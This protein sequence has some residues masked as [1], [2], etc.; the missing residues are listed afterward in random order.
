VVGALYL[1]EGHEARLVATSRAPAESLPLRFD[2]GGPS[3]VARAARE[4]RPI[5]STAERELAGGHDAAG[6]PVCVLPIERAGKE[7]PSAV[8]VAG[9]NPMRGLDEAYRDFFG[10]VA[11]QI[12]AAIANAEER[13]RAEALAEVAEAKTTF[14]SNV[15]H[16]FRTP[17]TLLLGPLQDTLANR[18]EPLPPRVCEAIELAQRNAQRL[19]KLV[20][21]LLDFSRIEAGRM[22]ASYVA[23]DLAAATRDLASMFRSAIDRAGLA[24]D[25]AGIEDLPQPVFVDRA[26]WEKIVS[27]LLSNAFKFTFEGRIRVVVRAAGE[28]AEVAIEDTGVGIAEHDLPKLFQR[29]HRIEGAPS[30][31]YEGSGIGLSFVHSLVGLHGA[32]IAVTSRLGEGSRFTITIPF[33]S[34]H[35]PP[36]RVD[37]S[38]P[39]PHRHRAPAHGWLRGRPATAGHVRREVPEARRRHGLRP[40]VRS[41]ALAR[42]RLRP[43]PRQTGRARAPVG[44]HRGGLMP[45]PW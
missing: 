34:A 7:G 42:S 23:T 37:T 8:L 16:E 5:E 13:R 14:F 33:G 28:R 11:R 15:S 6:G 35:L 4:M 24:F 10:L 36:D 45:P 38:P 17:L 26:M 30:R 22:Q 32:A 20:N 41:T 27:N 29:F 2:L 31:T 12:G 43:P 9:R 21:T 25:V 39:S 19:G 1:I 3:S 44:A 40:G 18:S